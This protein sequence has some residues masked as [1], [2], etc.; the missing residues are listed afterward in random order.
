MA[1]TVGF[2]TDETLDRFHRSVGEFTRRVQVVRADQWDQPTPCAEWDVRALV[3]HV[4]G[5]QRWMAPMLDGQTMA[6]IGSSLDGDL[7]GADPVDAWKRAVAQTAARLAR[8]GILE[9]VVQLRSGP[10]TVAR[11]CDEVAA[12]TL[13]HTW[14]LAQAIGAE[15]SLPGDLVDAATRIVEPWVAPE[16]VPGMLAPPRAVPADADP[17]T[18][19]LAMLGR[20]A[21]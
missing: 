11:F 8:P 19:L 10:A 7:L 6:Q 16:G 3:N 12:D 1:D 14:D 9:R 4:C 21:D 15:E 20:R 2:R 13:V 17:Q 5:E 18:A